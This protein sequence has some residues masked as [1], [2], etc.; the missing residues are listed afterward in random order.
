[1]SDIN[2]SVSNVEF[3]KIKLNASGTITPIPDSD[4]GEFYYNN[5]DSKLIFNINATTRSVV[6]N[7]ELNSYKT[8]VA[9]ATASNITYVH[10]NFLPLTGGIISGE[11][12]I[13]NNLTV[14]G[15]LTATGT[16]TF[17]NTIFSTT[18]ALSVVH[19][20]SGPAMWVGNNGDGDIASFYDIDSNV[21]VL[22]IGGNTGS[23]PN[24]GVKTSTP[25]KD[26][27]VNGEISASNTIYD[28]VGN[29]NQWNTAYNVATTYQDASGS[30]ATNTLLQSTSA[31]LT[32]LTTTN[33]LTGQL[34]LNTDFSNYQ[35]SVAT[36]TATL[37]PTSIYQNASGDW[38]RVFTTVQNNSASWEESADILPTV[39]NYLSTNNV[40]LSTLTVNGTIS[41]NNWLSAGNIGLQQADVRT[42]TNPATASGNFLVLNING[43]NRGIRL[44]D[45]PTS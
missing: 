13:N 11:T 38:Q 30:F 41:G 23:F 22:H 35:T 42:F 18:S 14:F 8:D 29:S 2:S 21:E 16:T 9:T 1:L 6:F 34:V 39:T 4:V 7:T 3:P 27:T 31:L 19:I 44:W 37:L 26:F 32:P 25:N 36:S 17:A 28:N 20:G 45:L 12:R 15:N 24:V 40:T 33:T 5:S 43:T 10:N